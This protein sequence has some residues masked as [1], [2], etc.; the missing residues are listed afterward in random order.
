MR[1]LRLHLRPHGLRNHLQKR[2]FQL[3]SLR[4]GQSKAAQPGKGRM[5]QGSL[6]HAHAVPQPAE[7]AGAVAADGQRTAVHGQHH[8]NSQRSDG[9]QQYLPG[10]NIQS[11][12]L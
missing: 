4:R 8:K 3:G 10:G 1:L 7:S 6:K 11:A 9:H 5:Q 12:S 2:I